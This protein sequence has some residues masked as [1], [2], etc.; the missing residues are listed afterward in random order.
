[1][2]R[3][4]QP[5]GSV[6]VAISV[7]SLILLTL[8]DRGGAYQNTQF[9]ASLIIACTAAGAW[10]L[11]PQRW[12]LRTP[13]VVLLPCLVWLAGFGQTIALPASVIEWASPHSA[14]AYQDWLPED[15]SDTSASSTTPDWIPI[16][17]APH[18]T[19]RALGCLAMFCAACWIARSWSENANAVLVFFL[20]ISAGGGALAVL[21]LLDRSTSAFGPFVNNNNAGSFLNLSIGCGLAGIA[22]LRR[23]RR[24]QRVRLLLSGTFWVA[25]ILSLVGLLASSS[26]GATL[27]LFAGVVG[28]G[29]VLSQND[30]RRRVVA[31]LACTIALVLIL[32]AGLGR[33][34]RPFARIQSLWNGNALDNPRVAHW[35]DGISASSHYLPAGSGLG[36]YRYAHLPFQQRGGDTWYVHADGMPVEC[37]LEGGVWL[38]TLVVLGVVLVGRDVF[39]I[40]RKR[41]ECSGDSL[42]LGDSFVIAAAFATPALLVAQCFDFGILQPPSFLL[43]ASLLGGLAF[44]SQRSARFDQQAAQSKRG[45]T[46]RSQSILRAVHPGL[47]AAMLCVSAF[48]LFVASEV[49]RFTHQRRAWLSEPIGQTP[50]R[51]SAI[52][53]LERL[54]AWKPA[55]S[56]IHLLL[57]N[58]ILDE[59]RRLGARYLSEQTI[60]PEEAAAMVSL[61]TYRRALAAT[62]SNLTFEAIL[63]PGQDADAWRRARDHVAAALG[64]NPFSDECRVLLIE[65][66][67]VTPVTKTL[68]LKYIE[69][70]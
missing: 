24:G 39:R 23:A 19:R 63:M 61:R 64:T 20:L 12:A 11:R 18:L 56:S 42:A 43:L 3:F 32:L 28:I 14:A 49:E 15:T 67:S 50:S 5:T 13:A 53:T 29:A 17:V 70:L 58:L 66:E 37:L 46:V 16:S 60:D 10:I 31:L 26:R 30:V 35:Q 38:T 1:M 59:Q 44:R 7:A 57:A 22:F 48:D 33:W 68:T 40:A 9:V 65:L 21:G 51:Q 6:L 36:T 69:Q 52:E 62:D 4:S 54:R 25:T 47:L 41:E 55:D 34:S 27:G 45:W 8:F 2:N